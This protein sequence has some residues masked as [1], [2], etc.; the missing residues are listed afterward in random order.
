MGSE[1]LLCK[2]VVTELYYSDTAV[3]RVKCALT[4]RVF[5]AASLSLHCQLC[6]HISGTCLREERHSA[7]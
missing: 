7:T 6:L 3:L 4:F 1:L 2:D 5:H